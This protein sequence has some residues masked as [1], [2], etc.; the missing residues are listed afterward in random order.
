MILIHCEKINPKVTVSLAKRM[1][2]QRKAR[3]ERERKENSVL[4]VCFMIDTLSLMFSIRGKSIN[5]PPPCRKISEKEGRL[6]MNVQHL[7]EEERKEIEKQEDST[8]LSTKKCT[9]F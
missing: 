2:A 6:L 8:M 5:T 3:L 7:S 9:V 1:E 4:I